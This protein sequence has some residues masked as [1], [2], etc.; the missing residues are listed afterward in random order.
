M[1]AKRAIRSRTRKSK[2]LPRRDRQ[3]SWAMKRNRTTYS[4]AD[5][6]TM[7]HS[8]T[9]S[10]SKEELK[11]WDAVVKE[12]LQH[13]ESNKSD[14]KNM[15]VKAIPLPNALQKWDFVPQ[16]VIA[17]P[18]T[19]FTKHISSQI[20]SGH[21]ALD[22][23]SGVAYAINGRPF[24]V[25]HYKGHPSETSTIYFPRNVSAIEQITALVSEIIQRFK[26]PPDAVL[27]Q[28]KDNPEL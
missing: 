16:A 26:L 19:A 15:V 23:Y 10:L 25:M 9:N 6:L 11:Q 13:L 3:Y 28:R 20:T 7:F 17:R 27:W 4:W 1:R 2:R 5:M 22:E 21:D 18:I 24:A 8:F 12:H 14:P